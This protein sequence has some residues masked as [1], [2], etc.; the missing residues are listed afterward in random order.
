MIVAS[1]LLSLKWFLRRLEVR[2]DENRTEGAHPA[3]GSIGLVNEMGD[4][5]ILGE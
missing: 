5:V 3:H 1:S 4:G 2:F